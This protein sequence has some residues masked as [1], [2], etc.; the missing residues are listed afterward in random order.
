MGSAQAAPESFNTAVPVAQ[1][2]FVFRGQFVL[3]QS[4]DD[5]SGAGRDRTAW[6]LVSVLGYGATP[7]LALFGVVPHV[8]KN[9]KLNQGD[10]R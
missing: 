5:P 1:G 7:V 3:D 10:A 8:D 4:D 2:E 9:L 6:A